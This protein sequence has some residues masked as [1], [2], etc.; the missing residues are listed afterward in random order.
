MLTP[1]IYPKSLDGNSMCPTEETQED[2]LQEGEG[3]HPEHQDHCRAEVEGAEVEVEGAEAEVEG[4]EAEA[5]AE[6]GEEH[7]HY[8]GKH[9][10][11]LL[12]IFW[13]THPQFSQE[14]EPKW[15]P[16]SHN[17]SCTA[18]SMQTTPPFKTNTR[19]QCYFSPIYKGT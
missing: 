6:E 19:R 10:L 1:R 17:G 4:A 14:T 13:E 5:E 15:T 11:M 9:P 2:H 18:A 3:N 12:K 8:P 7:S 16:S